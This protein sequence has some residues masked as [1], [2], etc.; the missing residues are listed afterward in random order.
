M[1]PIP[2]LKIPVLKIPVLTADED[3]G[4]GDGD[5]GSGD[6]GS[7]TD[8]GNDSGSD[9]DDGADTDGGD[10]GTDGGS[11]GYSQVAKLTASDAREGITFGRSLSLS[12][13]R[14]IVN[15]PALGVGK[16][17][18]FENAD[19]WNQVASFSGGRDSSSLLGIGISSSYAI[20]SQQCCAI[21]PNAPEV[22]S[23]SVRVYER[24][25]EGW[26]YQQ[27]LDGATLDYSLYYAAISEDY[28]VAAR[29]GNSSLGTYF[30]PLSVFELRDGSWIETAALELEGF[31]EGSSS[32]SGYLGFGTYLDISDS[33]VIASGPDDLPNSVFI[34]ERSDDTWSDAIALEPNTEVDGFGNGVAAAPDTA[35]VGGSVDGQDVVF[36]FERSDSGWTQTALLQRED[37]GN[38]NAEFAVD[39]DTIVVSAINALDDGVDSVDIYTNTD[40]GWTLSQTLQS[41][42]NV[43]T[44]AFG[45][46]VAISDGTIL[47]GSPG[48][49]ELG[50]NTGAVYV[51]ER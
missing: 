14:T 25:A 9:G 5:D 30:G 10:D 3:T 17:Y 37:G 11:E 36:V 16:A 51:Y 39:G 35:L 40:A 23:R 41:P 15:A 4:D 32:G 48:D 19:S 45:V 33:Y 26:S 50:E 2:V 42:A 13:N 20:T 47:V 12:E 1:I 24:D 8:A 46:A 28:I 43:R 38:Y 6:T 27:F 22:Y 7:D 34:F 31:T 29:E 49:D 44:D 21:R 18:I